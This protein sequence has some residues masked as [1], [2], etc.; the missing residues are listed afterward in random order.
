[1][2]KVDQE[3]LDKMESQYTGII[4]SIMRFENAE[5]P[6][7]PHCGSEDSADVQ[8]GVIGRTMSISAATSKFTLIPN[9]PRP[10]R[11]R[12]NS[13]KKYFGEEQEGERN[14]SGF[15]VRAK[16]KSL[17]EYK[18]FINK[19]MAQMGIESEKLRSEE[20]W[21]ISWGKYREKAGKK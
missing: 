12:C 20:E 21:E 15:T 14:G 6:P 1:M 8:V 18:A 13:C 4:E 5:L 16:V 3:T 9:G 17:Q 7:C 11:Y 2:L 10:G 19:M